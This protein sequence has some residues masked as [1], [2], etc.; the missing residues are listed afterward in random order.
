MTVLVKR[1]GIGALGVSLPAIV[2]LPSIA[3]AL[4]GYDDAGSIANPW[5]H[6]G[7]AFNGSVAWNTDAPFGYSVVAATQSSCANAVYCSGYF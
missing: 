6:N 4:S 2:G 3:R 7:C 1:L 5:I